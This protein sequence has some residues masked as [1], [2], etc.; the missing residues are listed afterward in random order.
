[1]KLKQYYITIHL[2]PTSYNF[3]AE[4][5]FKYFIDLSEL[6]D[7]GYT[8]NDVK[9]S[10][11]YNDGAKMSELLPWDED[12]H[13]YYVIGDF[14]GRKIYPGGQ[15]Q[16][17]AEVQFR[18]AGPENTNFWDNS[19]DY[20]YEEVEK[21]PG[22]TPLKTAKIPVY[23]DGKLVFGVEPAKEV[24]VLAGDINGDGTVD[25]SDYTLFR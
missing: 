24:K 23:D 6:Y 3:S 20:S 2:F 25:V 15:S 1:M 5:S 12:K 9:I 21:T 13:I 17:R 7:A 14:S 18:L 19:N 22:S 11:N 10:T 8:V 4:L 16:H